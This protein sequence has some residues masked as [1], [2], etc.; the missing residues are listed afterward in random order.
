MTLGSKVMEI[1]AQSQR[2]WLAAFVGCHPWVP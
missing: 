1:D 2:D